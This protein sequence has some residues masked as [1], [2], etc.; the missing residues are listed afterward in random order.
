MFTYLC[1]AIALGIMALLFLLAQKREKNHQVRFQTIFLLRQLVSLLRQHRQLTHQHINGTAN[2]ADTIAISEAN[3]SELQLKLDRV[4]PHSEFRILQEQIQLMHQKWA[5][6]NLARN[7]IVH[8]RLIRQSLYLIDETMIM[9][10]TESGKEDLIEQ[11]SSD[12]LD[13]FD[14]LDSLTQFRIA[15]I[16]KNSEQG[17]IKLERS[18]QSLSRRLNKLSLLS[19][20]TFV[21]MAQETRLTQLQ[22]SHIAKLCEEDLYQ[23][24]SEISS[25]IFTLYDQVISALCESLY[26][27]L[28]TIAGSSDEKKPVDIQQA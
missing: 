18:A 11:Y 10:L 14:G 24:S 6:F 7:Q 3:I 9:W 16:D 27:P 2:M 20:L 28:P 26:L 17:Q 15:I 5:L 13:V 4:N 22:N 23:M 1:I 8:G 19:P 25:V 21:D 12:W